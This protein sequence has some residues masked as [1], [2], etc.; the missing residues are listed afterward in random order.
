MRTYR[1]PHTDLDVT[2]LAYGCMKL[3]GNWNET[4]LTAADRKQAAALVAAALEV[5]INFFDHADIYCRT[6]SEEVFGGVL[7]QLPG[8]RDKI[9]LQSKVGIRFRGAPQPTD[10]GRYD[11]SYE[12]IK[13]TVEGSLR[14]LQTD[15]LDILL[16]HRPDA[17]VEP[18]EVARA[19]DELHASGKVRFFGVSNH[20]V[21]QI[22]LLQKYVRQPLVA[23]QLELNLLRN[24][25]MERGVFVNQLVAT[26]TGAD[27]LLDFCREQDIAIQAWAP[28]ANGQLID[29]PS[30]APVR[31]HRAAA[32]VAELATA[33]NTTREAIALGWLL[34]HPAGIQPIVGTYNVERIKASAPAAEVTLSREEW[35][36]LLEAARGAGV[37]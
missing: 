31:A 27:G 10:P 28:V 20:S 24:D 22:R 14:R 36:S 30:T 5:G 25:L 29:P 21:A 26:Y 23:N 12:H 33:H 15:R 13:A 16:L 11:F 37:P 32:R 8:V 7:A 18:A 6:K 4:P 1:L 17:L 34:R 2:C 9:V 35:Y 3:G 19:F